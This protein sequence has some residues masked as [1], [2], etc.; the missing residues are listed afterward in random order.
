MVKSS[1]RTY[2]KDFIVDAINLALKSDSILAT[3]NNLGIPVSTLHTWINK[4]KANGK[5]NSKCNGKSLSADMEKELIKLRK[6][7]ARLQEERDILKKAATF[8]AKE[9]K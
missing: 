5:I 8:F 3:A 6:D 2:D 7:N 9:S 1:K 4:Q